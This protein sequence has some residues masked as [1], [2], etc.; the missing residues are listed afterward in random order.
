[1]R[2]IKQFAVVWHIMCSKPSWLLIGSKDDLVVVHV[3]HVFACVNKADQL[4]VVKE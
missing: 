1:M 3:L 4:V 2:V